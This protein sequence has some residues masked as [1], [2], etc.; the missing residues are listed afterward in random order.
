MIKTIIKLAVITMIA[1]F[2]F[3]AMILLTP[4][5]ASCSTYPPNPA[6]YLLLVFWLCVTAFTIFIVILIFSRNKQEESK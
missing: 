4:S 1:L 6:D 2:S 3:L 5:T